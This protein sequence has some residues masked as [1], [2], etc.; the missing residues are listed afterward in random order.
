MG[1]ATFE[2]ALPLEGEIGYEVRRKTPAGRFES[3]PGVNLQGV[4]QAGTIID[5]SKQPSVTA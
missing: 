3:R 2:A 1:Q 4:S 5:E